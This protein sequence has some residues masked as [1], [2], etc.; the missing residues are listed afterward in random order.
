[1][2]SA[3]TGGE[4][5]YVN[6]IFFNARSN[7][8]STGKHYAIKLGGTGINPVGLLSNFNDL[9]ASG[10]DGKLGYYNLA[11]RLTLSDWRTATGQDCNSVSGDPRFV[12]PN[13]TAST[14]DLHIVTTMLL[15]PYRERRFTRLFGDH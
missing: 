6:N 7:S 2:N 5:K 4:R 12:A 14:V 15:T 1:M 8:G 10:V 13:G 3:R 11:D 9:L